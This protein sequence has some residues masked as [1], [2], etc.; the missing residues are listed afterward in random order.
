M[1]RI[2]DRIPSVIHIGRR[3]VAMLTV[4]AVLVWQSV[5]SCFGSGRWTGRKPWLGKERWRNSK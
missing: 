1:L 2:G 3:R 5:R 4:G